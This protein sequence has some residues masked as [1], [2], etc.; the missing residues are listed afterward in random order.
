VGV[1][2]P[3]KDRLPVALAGDTRVPF[4]VDPDEGVFMS[5]PMEIVEY[6]EERHGPQVRERLAQ[7][8]SSG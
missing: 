5:N 2:R 3:N 4:L 7:L 6:L 1:G 8:A